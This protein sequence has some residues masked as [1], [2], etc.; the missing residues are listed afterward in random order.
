MNSATVVRRAVAPGLGALAWG[1]GEAASAQTATATAMVT[2]E[3][4]EISEA[5]LSNPPQPL[6]VTRAPVAPG[7]VEAEDG[8]TTL[9]VTTN[10][11]GWKITGVLDSEMPPGTTL[12]V[13]LTTPVGGASAGAVTLGTVARDLAALASVAPVSWTFSYRF[14]AKVEAG[15]VPQGR[16][17]M[18]LTLVGGA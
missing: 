6:L 17:T 5:W 9:T 3:V 14:S 16:R 4:R 11:A 7:T 18:I 15:L 10:A 2:Y 8:G 13:A 12:S 1:S